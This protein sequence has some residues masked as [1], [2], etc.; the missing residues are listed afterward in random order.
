MKDMVFLRKSP[1][2]SAAR[3]VALMENSGDFG[4]FFS[5]KIAYSA[6]STTL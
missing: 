1:E 3:A 5:S 6:A 4:Q 2:S